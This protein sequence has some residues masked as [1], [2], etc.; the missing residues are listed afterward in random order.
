MPETERIIQVEALTGVASAILAANGL[1]AEDARYCAEC[2]VEA[3]L[4]GVSSHGVARLPVYARRLREGIL[5]PAPTLTVTERMP[6]AAHVDGDNGIGFVV[7]RK[8]MDI[9]IEKAAIY[10]V[11]LAAASR[12]AVSRDP[13]GASRAADSRAATSVPAAAPRRS[14]CQSS[15]QTAGS[16]RPITTSS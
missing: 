16:S 6:V 12:A 10:G 14:C 13:D 7:A 5:N 3:D 4:R 2:L 9:A 1:P 11:G 15:I 8:A